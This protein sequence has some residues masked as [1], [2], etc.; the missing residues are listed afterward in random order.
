MR[1]G[2]RL[3]KYLSD[4]QKKGQFSGSAIVTKG[5]DVLLSKG[6]GLA[7]VEHG[8]ANTP[9][10]HFRIGSITKQFT[11]MGIMTLQEH[12]KL[13]VTDTVG[14][15]LSDVPK[16]WEE[17]TIHQLLTHTSG[18][19][20]SWALP[21]FAKTMA[22]PATID[23]V[24]ERYHDQPLLF[25]PGEDLRYSGVGYFLLAKLIEETSGKPY[26]AFMK[27]A[28]FEPLGMR[29]T[30]ADGPDVVLKRRA[31]G[32]IFKND[33]LRNAPPIHIPILAGGGDLYSTVE[34]MARWDRGLRE[35]RL[36]SAAGYN[37]MYQPVLK[38]YAYG[39]NV[40]K[41][42]GRRVLQ[43]GGSVPGFTSFILRFPDEELC[44]VV[45]TN[46]RKIKVGKIADRL[47]EIV[48]ESD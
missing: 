10:T 18:I 35:K 44:I 24:L 41:K 20:H 2:K 9:K 30:G 25:T 8:I 45:L 5:D 32:Y 33:K 40:S 36:I 43:H 15:H 22:V 34:D 23:Q 29:D 1:F 14:K 16:A 38:D 19:M 27:E 4:I 26:G 28:V 47:A 48:H 37:A 7:D 42:G 39:W 11:A 3:D 21:G 13:S 17:L 6:Y 12:G 46:S 31:K